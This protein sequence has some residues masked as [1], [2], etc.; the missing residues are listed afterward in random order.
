MKYKADIRTVAYMIIT[1]LMFAYQWQAGFTGFGLGNWALY[2][3]YLHFAV[4]VSVITHNHNHLQIW[5]YKALNV[6]TDWW[7]TVFYGIPIFTWI[8]THN[9]N[10]HRYVNKQGDSTATYRKTESNDLFTLV[11]YPGMSSYYQITEGIIPFMKEMKQKDKKRYWEYLTQCFVLIAWWLL[12]IVIDWKKALVFVVIPQQVSGYMVQIF[13][14][15]QHVHADEE[16][17]YNHSRNF[18]GVNLFLF[19]NGYHTAHH[20]RASM[21]WSEAAEGHAQIADKIDPSLNE[22]SF[23]GYI[24]RTYIVGAVWKKY[25]SQ[26]M[27]LARQEREQPSEVE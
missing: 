26:S 1:S 13:N 3:V 14:Y 6:L 27:R 20:E 17:K 25:S 15:V 10:H 12:W 19:N 7:L 2:I 24:F 5:N 11:S 4:A 9:R 18:M 16:T 8:P 21:H 22:K 23:W